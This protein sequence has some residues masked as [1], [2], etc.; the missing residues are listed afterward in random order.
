MTTNVKPRVGRAAAGGPNSATSREVGVRNIASSVPRICSVRNA[1]PGP[2]RI[3]ESHMYI[4]NPTK[5]KP[6]T[7]TVPDRSA[8][9]A[10]AF[11]SEPE[12][13]LPMST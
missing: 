13:A 9:A 12:Y 4:A 6:A 10:M 7:S 2:H 8:N 11:G 1:V 3:V 5:T